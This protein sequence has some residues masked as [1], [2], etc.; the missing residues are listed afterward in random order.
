MSIELQ[1][2]TFLWIKK[3]GAYYIYVIYYIYNAH[4]VVLQYDGWF[5]SVRV[6]ILSYYNTTDLLFETYKHD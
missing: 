2:N 5:C 4:T 3:I 1:N 6:S